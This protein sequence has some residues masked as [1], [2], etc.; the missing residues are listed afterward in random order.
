MEEMPDIIRAAVRETL[1]DVLSPCYFNQFQGEMQKRITK[2][3]R[4]ELEAPV[5]RRVINEMED[6]EERIRNEYREQVRSDLREELMPQIR[7]EIREELLKKFNIIT[8]PGSM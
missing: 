6:I 4:P 5:K 1:E 3:L 2:I 8:G 7:I